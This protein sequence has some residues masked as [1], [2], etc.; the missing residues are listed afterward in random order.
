[1]RAFA[2]LVESLMRPVVVYGLLPRLLAWSMKLRA[3]AYAR[4]GVLLGRLL[5][6]LCLNSKQDDDGARL[7]NHSQAIFGDLCFCDVFCGRWLISVVKGCRECGA[8]EISNT[9]AKSLDSTATS[10]PPP[11]EFRIIPARYQRTT[12][13]AHGTSPFNRIRGCRWMWLPGH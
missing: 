4:L 10:A 13:E 7:H 11:L 12:T 5:K 1:M 8:S 2:V 6:I 3:C 9:W